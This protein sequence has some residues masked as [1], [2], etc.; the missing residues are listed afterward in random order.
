MSSFE[1]SGSLLLPSASQNETKTTPAY[2]NQENSNLSRNSSLSNEPKTWIGRKM[3][4]LLRNR[5]KNHVPEN[6]KVKETSENFDSLTTPALVDNSKSSLAT[7]MSLD[8]SKTSLQDATTNSIF[9]PAQNLAFNL[10]RTLRRNKKKKKSAKHNVTCQTPAQQ[11][12]P[13]LKNFSMSNI[14]HVSEIN[15]KAPGNVHLS[16]EYEEN[17]TYFR[18]QFLITH[19]NSD[20]KELFENLT[21]RLQPTDASLF[22]DDLVVSAPSSKSQRETTSEPE[23]GFLF[24]MNHDSLVSRP[25]DVELRREY[26][27]SNNQS[28][29]ED[30]QRETFLTLDETAPPPPPPPPPRNIK[31]VITVYDVSSGNNKNTE[32]ISL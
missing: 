3:T 7:G 24:N 22:N 8:D 23:I 29:L 10:S 18:R 30:E 31:R 5:S 32:I 28:S 1:F 9:R 17:S 25:P 20:D 16:T 4:R 26:T 15:D 27:S 19:H 6:E 2:P 12:R 13:K 11:K 21:R 14:K